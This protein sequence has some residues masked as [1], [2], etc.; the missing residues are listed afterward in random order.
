M[1]ARSDGLT[2]NHARVHAYGVTWRPRRKPWIVKFKR[3]KCT[4]YIG[5]YFHLHEAELSAAR[6]LRN[7]K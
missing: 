2:R 4:V 7:E 3:N 5:S 6:Y 1:N